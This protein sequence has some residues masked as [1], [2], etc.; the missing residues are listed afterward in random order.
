MRKLPLLLCALLLS[1]A[2]GTYQ[3]AGVIPEFKEEK[4]EVADT[5]VQTEEKVIAA[6]MAPQAQNPS[7]KTPARKAQK[8]YTS[9]GVFSAYIC[10]PKYTKSV[11]PHITADGTDLRKET[12]C[13]VANNSLRFGTKIDIE[14]IGTCVVK[15]RMNPLYA[16]KHKFDLHV[17]SLAY[18]KTFGVKKLR[19]SIVQN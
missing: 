19:Y 17:G 3:A 13:V 5:V 14:G 12:C 4:F 7:I 18:A 9:V 2:Q 8:S 16:S 10:G 1:C 6:S 15:D 11:N